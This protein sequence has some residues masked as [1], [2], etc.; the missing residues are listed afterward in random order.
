M[1]GQGTIQSVY[2]CLLPHC[3]QD[4][5]VPLLFSAVPCQ[6]MKQSFYYFLGETTD[7]DILHIERQEG[8]QE[9]SI[10]KDEPLEAFSMTG[11]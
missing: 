2:L 5:F 1:K 11:K 10:H 8:I 3:I 4:Y 7:R 9:G 6:V